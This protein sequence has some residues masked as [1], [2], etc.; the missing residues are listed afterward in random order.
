MLIL[1]IKQHEILVFNLFLCL[2]ILRIVFFFG[3]VCRI[4]V[5]DVCV[6]LTQIIFVSRLL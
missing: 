4:V 2:S 6:K 5:S 3:H 1:C